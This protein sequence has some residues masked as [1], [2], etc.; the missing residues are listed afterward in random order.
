MNSAMTMTFPAKPGSA[1]ACICH[2]GCPIEKTKILSAG[3]AYNKQQGNM[4]K[5]GCNGA[6]TGLV[7][8]MA[9]SETREGNNMLNKKVIALDKALVDSS[10]VRGAIKIY[11]YR[12]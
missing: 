2:L 11:E 10:T 6:F 12:K 1:F 7:G 5:Q 8:V 9:I 3:W 4:M